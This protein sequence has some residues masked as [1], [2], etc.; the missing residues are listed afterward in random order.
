M[1]LPLFSWGQEIPFKMF[2]DLPV[3][4]VYI[5]ENPAYLLIDTGASVSLIDK[6]AAERYGFVCWKKEATDVNGIGGRAETYNTGKLK[7]FTKDGIRLW[8]FEKA[9]DLY[10]LRR[11]KKV[12]G[13]LGS[14][15]F[16][17]GWVIDFERT[18]LL[19]KSN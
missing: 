11:T 13:I 18:Q 8:G 1:L 5:N 9:I 16:R 15:F 7:I 10:N 6:T 3:I 19:K 12:V 4:E 17:D 14:D 2:K